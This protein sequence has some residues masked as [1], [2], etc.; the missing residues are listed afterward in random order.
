MI[1]IKLFIS[2][3]ETLNMYELTQH[4]CQEF[5]ARLNPATGLVNKLIGGGGEG[6]I[7]VGS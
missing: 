1:C 5:L 4:T 6:G 3:S 7:W 2:A